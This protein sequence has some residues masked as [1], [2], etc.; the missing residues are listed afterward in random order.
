M[1]KGDTVF[2]SNTA[3]TFRAVVE[4]KHRD[5]SVTVNTLFRVIHPDP[6]SNVGGYRDAPGYYGFKYR[7]D[8]EE[9]RTTP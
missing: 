7:L 3:G 4:R 1:T 5:G 9:L 2:Y 8:A 6:E